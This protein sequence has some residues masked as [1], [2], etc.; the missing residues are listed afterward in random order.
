[1]R[2]S[3]SL[4]ADELSPGGLPAGGRAVSL[5]PCLQGISASRAMYWSVHRN[6]SCRDNEKS[7][8][9]ARTLEPF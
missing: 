2:E 3:H 5:L 6:V 8:L 7:D 4:S 9:Q 1:M